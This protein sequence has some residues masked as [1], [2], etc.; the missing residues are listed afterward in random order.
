MELTFLE[1]KDYF[2]ILHDK[3]NSGYFTD[4][5][6]AL[7]LNRAQMIFLNEHLERELDGA[8]NFYERGHI[9][10]RSIENTLGNTDILYPLVVSDMSEIN[11]SG[12]RLATNSSG[13]L[14]RSDLL[15]AITQN[16]GQSTNPMKILYFGIDVSG[17]IYPTSAEYVR[18]NDILKFLK[19]SFL[20]PTSSQP[21]WTN[22]NNGYQ[23]Y[24]KEILNLTA[25][26]L[27]YPVEMSDSVD[28]EL[29]G[30]THDRIVSIALELAGVGTR[31]E[32][33]LKLN[34]FRNES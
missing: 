24:P 23:F 4:D 2:D 9:D 10:A 1:M 14:S 17:E 16:S 13:F 27:R 3:Y 11:G 29:Q 21:L 6:K 32:N 22:D 12:D 20:S 18:Q 7:F 26:V 15:S 25:S 31:D 8:L 5:E 34:N 30:S 28:C 19:N 33:L